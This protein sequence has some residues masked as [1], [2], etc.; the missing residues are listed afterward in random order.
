MPKIAYKDKNFSPSSL[1]V[2]EQANEIIDEYVADGL[3]LTLRQL[4]Y[5]FV[6]RDL[7]ANKQSEYKRLGSIINDARMAGLVDWD[8][9]EDRT[10]NLRSD[11]HWDDPGDIMKSVVSSFRLDRWE[12][13]QYRVEVWIEKEA[14]IG[15]IASICSELDVPY[16]ACKGYVSASEMWNASQRF[17]YI[18]TAQKP[19]II[20]L[21]DHDPSG[22]DMTRDIDDRQNLFE[23]SAIINRIALNFDQVEKYN[24]PPNPAKLSDSRASGYIAKYGAYSWELDAL[25]PRTMRNL[26]SDTIAQYRDNETHQNRLELENEYKSILR[27]VEANWKEL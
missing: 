7:I 26:I 16:F 19:V 4:Y 15:V 20:H 9:I 11:S 22:I 1:S 10:R 5:Q 27:K 21:G 8:S 25:E 18:F 3:K 2:I 12:G 13:Q 6:S 24:P 14:L 23:G 17:K